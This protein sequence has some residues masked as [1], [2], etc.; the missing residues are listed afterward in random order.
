MKNRNE[1]SVKSIEM[2]KEQLWECF[3]SYTDLQ[4]EVARNAESQEILEYLLKKIT[5][6]IDWSST[7]ANVSIFEQMANNEDASPEILTLLAKFGN[8]GNICRNILNNK[9]TPLEALLILAKSFNKDV[10]YSVACR[11]PLHPQ[12]LDILAR[13]PSV[14]IRECISSKLEN[15]SVESLSILA[16]DSSSLVRM[17]VACNPN[18]PTDMLN[19]LS[20][21]KDLGVRMSVAEN[22]SVTRQILVRF[23]KDEDFRIRKEVASNSNT[24]IDILSFL[25]NDEDFLVRYYVALNP[26]TPSYVV[27]HM[28]EDKNF[29]SRCFSYIFDSQV[30]VLNALKS[31][32]DLFP[33]DFDFS[34][35]IQKL[36]TKTK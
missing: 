19:E 22:P 8:Y 23:S 25:S 2:L 21:D 27:N 15:I 24:P 3:E 11:R 12:I 10:R 1:E 13:D 7:W 17:R 5:A 36:L 28:M 18:T 20:Q 34:S 4:L 16:K 6:N 30:A 35:Y 26:N 14:E 9:N 29:A 33:E 31:L 32:P